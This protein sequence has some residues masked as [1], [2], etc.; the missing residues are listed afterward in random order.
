MRL[1]A[2]ATPP[3]AALDGRASAQLDEFKT[4]ALMAIVR[5][6]NERRW[7][8]EIEWSRVLHGE[9]PTAAHRKL[10][11]IGCALDALSLYGHIVVIKNDVYEVVFKSERWDAV[12]LT[13]SLRQAKQCL[14]DLHVVDMALRLVQV[15]AA[16][17]GGLPVWLCTSRTQPLAQ[18]ASVHATHGG[19]WGLARACRQE[20]TSLPVWCVDV[21]DGAHGL[22]TMMDHHTFRLSGG[23]VRGL[24]QSASVEPETACYTIATDVPRLVTPHD[25]QPTTFDIDFDSVCQLLHM[26]ATNA[27]DS[28]DMHQLPVAYDALEVMCQQYVA[29]AVSTLHESKVPLWHHK[30]LHAWCVKQHTARSEGSTV[31]RDVTHVHSSLW[32]E[33]QLGETCG[34]RL[35][36]ALTGAV[37]Y[38][39]L[40]FPGGSLDFARPVYEDSS[41]AAFYNGCVVAAVKTVIGLLS[42]GRHIAALEVGAGTGGTASSVLPVLTDSCERYTFTDVSDLFLRR[43]R[44]RFAEYPFIEYAMLNIDAD[45]RLQGFARSQCDIIISTN[46]LHATP[47]MRNTMHNCTQLLHVGG[48]VIVNELVEARTFFQVTFGMT[49]GWWLFAEVQDPERIGQISPLLDWRQWEALLIDSGFA[50]SH[51]VQGDTFLRGQ[52]VLVAQVESPPSDGGASDKLSDGAHFFSGGLGGLGLLTARLLAVY[53]TRQ[54]ILSSRSDRV[55]AGSETEWEW[56]ACSQCVVRRIRCDTSDDGAVRDTMRVMLGDGLRLSGVYHT[57]H[58]LADNVLAN[59]QAL[60]FRTTYGPKVQGTRALHAST[61]R[62]SPRLF[63]MYSSIAGLMGSAAQAPHAAASAWLDTMA[64]YRRCL[65]MCGQGVN[66]GVVAEIG[67]AARVGYNQRAETFGLGVIP[68]ATT[69]VALSNTL[70][71]AC[72]NF[73]VLPADWSKLLAGSSAAS[74]LCAPY[75]HLR[76]VECKQATVMCAS[77]TPVSEKNVIKLD[78]VL[79]LV[80][81][82]AGGFVDADAA[83]ME[84]GVDSLGAVELRNQLQHM[85]GAGVTL[86]STLI[87]DHPTA[88][89]LARFIAPAAPPQP[90]LAGMQLARGSSVVTLLSKK[91]TLPLGA[92]T[93]SQLSAVAMD[94]VTE[95]PGS[96][97][98]PVQGD[99]FVKAQCRYAAFMI[100]LECFDNRIFS[101]SVAESYA[102]DPQQRLV[103]S[104]S[105]T[106]MHAHGLRRHELLGSST[107][108]YLGITSTEFSQVPKPASAYGIGGVGHCFACGR[109]SYLLGLQGPCAATDTACSSTL[110]AAHSAMRALQCNECHIAVLSGVH[111]ML[112][113][114]VAVLYATGGI[115][116]KGG[117]SHTFD[118]R[119]DGFARSEACGSAL[120]GTEGP[121]ERT[122]LASAAV[123]QDGKS[124]SFTAPSGQ[125]QTALLNAAYSLA[126]MSL[127]CL[128]AHGTGTALGDPI[129]IGA[130]VVADCCPRAGTTSFGVG[131]IKANL[132]HTEPAAGL[133]GMF[134]LVN[135]LARHQLA[136]SAQLRLLNKHLL[137]PLS[138]TA[139]ACATQLGAMATL[140]LDTAGGVSSFGLGGTIAHAILHASSTGPRCAIPS[141]ALVYKRRLFLYGLFSPSHHVIPW[142][143]DQLHP[144]VQLHLQTSVGAYIFRSPATGA[145]H[146]LVADHVVQGRVVFPAA[147][148]L[149]VAHAA[150]HAAMSTTMM[151]HAVHFMQPLAIG[152]SFLFIECTIDCSRFDVRSYESDGLMVDGPEHCSGRIVGRK[153]CHGADYP[154]ARAQSSLHATSVSAL[155]NALYATGVLYGP[156][157]RTLLC[158]WQGV[159]GAMGQHCAHKPQPATFVHP[160]DVDDT[161]CI[162]KLVMN[163]STNGLLRLPFATDAVMLGDGVTGKLWT[164]SKS[165]T[166]PFLSLVLHLLSV[167]VHVLAGCDARRCGQVFGSPCKSLQSVSGAAHWV[168]AAHTASQSDCVAAPHVCRRLADDRSRASPCGHGDPC[169]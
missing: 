89:G 35:G 59:Q 70:L 50:R 65:G 55:V 142:R 110:V 40:L 6:S 4:R 71:P 156:G 66:W 122:Q 102:M 34:P 121:G 2:H 98:A 69:I 33:V 92:N 10:L 57:A 149:E 75:F 93:T 112:V 83:L 166:D 84:A 76:N 88:R 32:A 15:Q 21:W 28:L 91:T 44:V 3:Q 23:Y 68:R 134:K 90:Q 42:D 100:N 73:A 74:G 117:R 60:H 16:D 31:P 54:I 97:W 49:D 165:P 77:K 133:V 37:A 106:A 8:H 107:G 63:N 111:A 159:H 161:L 72:R 157:Y 48:M 86:P 29:E 123:R 94:T 155:Y 139:C 138:C 127:V 12:V 164:V 140:A 101:T 38:Q 141:Q 9:K 150:T 126:D 53:G 148:Y 47:F 153:T 132:G 118:E 147:G 62:L 58:A 80:K 61:G 52:S 125:A 114:A 113:P 25:V 56:L 128:E 168:S 18:T 130:L 160:A 81:R 136:P 169:G 167:I 96:R 13:A 143:H 14:T 17:D 36:D 51:C 145:L 154:L 103:L 119:A 131:G 82:T 22:V 162:G 79:E 7:H 105:Y 163:D 120:L 27:M 39:E 146:A 151:F 19:L 46:C 95:V 115:L 158:A 137:A 24:Q 108:I 99:D 1:G 144:F 26:H 30:L 45:P 41:M 78:A 109:L 104:D 11:V 43:A 87:F 116:S 124:A 85:A 64:N 20:Y 129:E 67:Y 5:V 135:G 152:H